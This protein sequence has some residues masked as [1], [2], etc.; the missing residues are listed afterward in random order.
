MADARAQNGW[1]AITFGFV[2][3]LDWGGRAMLPNAFGISIKPDSPVA[4]VVTWIFG[5][6]PWVF[7]SIAVVL[8]LL[9]FFQP[10]LFRQGALADAGA[11]SQPASTTATGA[12]VAA[13]VVGDQNVVTQEVHNHRYTSPANDKHSIEYLRKKYPKREILPKIGDDVV[14]IYGG[15]TT[16]Q[17]DTD[18]N[19]FYKNRWLVISGPFGDLKVQFSLPDECLAVFATAFVTVHDYA[20]SMYFRRAIWLAS[21]EHVNM[22]EDI[23]VLGQL[24]AAGANY[25]RLD[26]CELI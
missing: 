10:T 26:E 11:S 15:K 23:W 7:A 3:V 4:H 1:G 20:A 18:F 19:A 9:Y 12:G 5:F 2:S 22:G 21:L 6:P 14:A 25:S 8:A 24:A 16:H 13:T 17:G